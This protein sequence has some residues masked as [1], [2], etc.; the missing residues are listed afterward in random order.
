VRGHEMITKTNSKKEN[1]L[2][3]LYDIRLKGYSISEYE[4][5][6]PIILDRA[7]KGEL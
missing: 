7:F 5:F 4:E 1:R 3:I 2:P 6:V